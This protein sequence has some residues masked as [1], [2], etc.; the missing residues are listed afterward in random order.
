M[1]GDCCHC[2]ALIFDTHLLSFL[3]LPTSPYLLSSPA[4]IV[5][6]IIINIIIVVVVIIVIIIIFITIIIVVIIIVTCSDL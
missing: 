3:D 4:Q 5:G 1:K 6:G 2:N